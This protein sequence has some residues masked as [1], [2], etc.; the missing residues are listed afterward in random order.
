MAENKSIHG[1]WQNRWTFILAATGSAVGLGNIWKFPYMAGENGGG[2]FVLIYLVFVATIGIPVM[3]AEVM[4]G[5]RGRQSPVNTMKTLAK[6]SDASKFWGGIGWLGAVAGVLI[7]SFYSVIAGWA[8]AYAGK[9]IGGGLLDQNDIPAQFGAFVSDPLE[10]VLWHSLFMVMVLTVVAGGIHKGLEKSVQF[11]MPALFV[12]LILL[13]GYATTTGSFGEAVSFLFK[14]NPEALTADAVLSA[15]GHSFFTLSLGM[16]AIMA[17]GAYMPKEHSLGKTVVIIGVLDTLVAVVAGLVIFSIV[18]A[19][20]LDAAAGPSLMFKTLPVAFS[21]MPG[22]IVLGGVFFILVTF[23]AW[24][25]AISLAEPAVAWMVETAGFS[26][27]KAALVICIPVWLLG[28]ACALSQNIWSDVTILGSDLL[29]FL[30]KLTTNIMLPLG[31]LLI[32][33][34][35]GWI[36][37]RSHVVKEV[38][39]KNF[40]LFNIWIVIIRIVAPIGIAIVMYNSI[41]TWLRFINT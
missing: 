27:I 16:G 26:R 8:M 39:M 40:A 1:V 28:I 11:L 17:Y 5:R 38:A 32:A 14:F 12:M 21:Q 31:G 25:S 29:D 23:A 4:L 36:M 37:R 19:N 35:A 6:S 33:I 10:T 15:L 2:A 3:L 34:F 22:G 41:E 20:G 9:I 24:T 18:F 13:L 7:L 30:D